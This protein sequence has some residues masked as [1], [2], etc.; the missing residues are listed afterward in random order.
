M[1]NGIPWLTSHRVH[2]L[3]ESCYPLAREG[4]AAAPLK[5]TTRDSYHFLFSIIL[6]SALAFFY[7]SFI[8]K[9]GSSGR[10]SYNSRYR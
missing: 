3:S 2:F 7:G 4:E 6:G 9:G 8:L 5:D 1:T 10:N